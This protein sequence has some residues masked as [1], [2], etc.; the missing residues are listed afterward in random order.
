[1]ITGFSSDGQKKW[2]RRIYGRPQGVRVTGFFAW[3]ADQNT[4]NALQIDAATGKTITT[5]KAAQVATETTE[6]PEEL[7]AA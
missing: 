2:S 6:L 5:I 3:V 7:A 4:G 1:M